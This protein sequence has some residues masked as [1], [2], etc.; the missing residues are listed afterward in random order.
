MI[1]KLFF[2][3]P[4]MKKENTIINLI[5]DYFNLSNSHVTL[6]LILKLLKMNNSDPELFNF[7]QALALKNDEELKQ[8]KIPVDV[9][10][11]LNKGVQQ[12]GAPAPSPLA[13]P[14]LGAPA[15][16][17]KAPPLPGAP[18]LSLPGA[19][20]ATQSSTPPGA[21]PP[22][23]APLPPGASLLG[24]SP[25]LG[26]PLSPKAPPLPGAL[27]LSPL[28]A[29][30]LAAPAL[31]APVPSPP[32][33]LA[34]PKVPLPPGAPSPPGAFLLK[35][36]P[37]LGAPLP[38]PLPPPPLPPL[39]SKGLKSG[40]LA[41]HKTPKDN[42]NRLKIIEYG[43]IHYVPLFCLS[44]SIIETFK[45]KVLKRERHISVTIGAN[46]INDFAGQYTNIVHWLKSQKNWSHSETWNKFIKNYFKN[47][48]IPNDDEDFN[49]FVE[50]INKEK[51][52]DFCKIFDNLKIYCCILIVSLFITGF[53]K[54]L[55][56]SNVN[57]N[58][59][60]DV[61]ENK[62]IGYYFNIDNILNACSLNK[63]LNLFNYDNAIKTNDKSD[64]IYDFE[65][66]KKYVNKFDDMSEKLKVAVK[67][68]IDELNKLFKTCVKPA[69]TKKIKVKTKGVILKRN[70]EFFFQR[71]KSE[72]GR[73]S[74]LLKEYNDVYNIMEKI[75]DGDMKESYTINTKDKNKDAL[76]IK[77]TKEEIKRIYDY[78][79]NEIKNNFIEPNS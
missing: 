38:L 76:T 51:K 41:L 64:I 23:G 78:N 69:E 72:D 31:G 43:K 79:K 53:K 2:D 12:L 74:Y 56:G 25:P 36:S 67:D 35:E 47:Y 13:A 17:P 75:K 42:V 29:P 21:P 54:L 49:S 18:V 61:I 24:V 68:N 30:A 63:L 48:K 73:W 16:P 45:H 22:P 4:S 9:F 33:A 14:L 20:G 52:I 3:L 44:K 46:F 55:D 50:K 77:K 19:P 39:P 34:L 8:I 28:V 70:E 58:I 27:V 59:M 1:K 7:I 66:I 26:A 5:N 40:Q 10:N 62:T 15:P 11:K 71:M 32:G 57:N 60:F 65:F 6:K 37:P